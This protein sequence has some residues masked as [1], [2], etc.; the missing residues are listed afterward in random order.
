[1]RCDFAAFVEGIVRGN[2][3]LRRQADDLAE[4]LVQ[5][6]RY[7]KFEPLTGGDEKVAAIGRESEALTEMIIP[8][9]L[10]LLPPDDL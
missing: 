6:L 4:V 10:G 1:M 8:A 7:G 3:S 5:V 9:D 2:P